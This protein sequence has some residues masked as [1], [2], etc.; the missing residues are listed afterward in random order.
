MIE[1]AGAIRDPEYVETSSGLVIPSW[2]AKEKR[3]PKGVDLFCGAG[4]FS[5][6]FMQAGFEVVAAVDNDPACAST[7]MHNL[8]SFPC[9]FHYIEP[10]DGARLEKHFEKEFMGGKKGGIRQGF[11]SGGGWISHE[12]DTPGC[13]H[14]FFGDISKLSGETILRAVGMERGELDCV[15]GS[16]PCQGFSYAGKQNVADPRNALVWEFARLV[17]ELFP[18]TMVL[19]NVHGMLHM[20]TPDGLPVVDRLIRILEDGDFATADALGRAL[21]A[22]TGV[23]ATMRGQRVRGRRHGPIGKAAKGRAPGQRSV[24][25]NQQAFDFGKGRGQKGRS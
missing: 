20:V 1:L 2:I 15:M 9:Q 23:F 6:G 22:Q 3:R 14:F 10:E 19:E 24:D 12:R 21:K 25:R 17:I 4:G 13:E 18:K 7:Y 8:G 5:L 16:P 11:V